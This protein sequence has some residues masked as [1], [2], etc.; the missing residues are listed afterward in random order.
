M[1]GCGNTGRAEDGV[2]F[3]NVLTLTGR[4]AFI[5]RT[6]IVEAF[7]ELYDMTPNK[8]R[9]LADGKD[10]ASVTIKEQAAEIGR[11]QALIDANSILT[12]ALTAAGYERYDTDASGD[13]PDTAY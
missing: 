11:L 3:P 1:P 10:K 12:D 4:S 8:A 2:V 6:S 7:A 9:S 13:D 5:G